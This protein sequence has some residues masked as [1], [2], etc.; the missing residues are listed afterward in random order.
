VKLFHDSETKKIDWEQ[1]SQYVTNRTKRQCL[2]R[3]SKQL[4]KPRS[5]Q[6]RWTAEEDRLLKEAVDYVSKQQPK[7]SISWMTVS[8]RMNGIRTPSQCV[9]R[10]NRVHKHG[11]TAI[12]NRWQPD[13]VAVSLSFS[14][15]LFPNPL[16]TSSRM[17]PFLKQFPNPKIWQGIELI[18]SM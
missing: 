14:C 16:S 6:A 2:W 11:E 13:E 15:S 18:G 17:K 3:W 5:V 1:V 8:M 7:K 4:S 12:Y 10:W 9:N